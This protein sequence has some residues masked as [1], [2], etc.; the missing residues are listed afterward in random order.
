MNKYHKAI[1]NCPFPDGLEERMR[2][3]VLSASPPEKHRVFKPKVSKKRLIIAV[4]ALTL[5][6]TGAA[7]VV[8]WDPFFSQRYGIFNIIAENAFRKVNV[9]AVCDDV[10][11]TVREVIG[12]SNSISYILD[13]RLPDDTPQ[14]VLERL[15]AGEGAYPNGSIYYLM[16]GD[17][18]WEEYKAS[19]AEKWENVDWADY[20]DCIEYWSS[21]DNLVYDYFEQ[22]RSAGESARLR[23]NMETRTIT[24]LWRYDLRSPDVNFTSQPMTIVM[25]PPVLT[26]PNIALADHPALITFQPDYQTTERAG[27]FNAD[28][29]KISARLTSMGCSID[30][31]GTEYKSYEDAAH[32]VT[33]IHSSG[34]ELPL[35]LAATLPGGSES[36]SEEGIA[37]ELDFTARFI[38]LTDT[39]KITSV[40]VGEH[41]ITLHDAE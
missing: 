28:G 9:T 24:Y 18:T 31:Q 27:T 10:T 13:Y 17:V 4:A 11:I 16:R 8:P 6:T 37:E 20:R 34:L 2:E 21:N 39:S 7:F 30:Y 32:D 14:E 36:R 23:F 19:D 41:E 22:S 25:P 40:R 12:D 26:R 35:T 15:E 5:L 3:K 29:I 33:L 38:L 1:D